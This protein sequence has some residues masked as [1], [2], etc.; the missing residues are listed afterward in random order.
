LL[1]AIKSSQGENDLFGRIRETV[2]N[3]M[4]I[5]PLSKFAS[6]NENTKQLRSI[7]FAPSRRSDHDA[8]TT[9]QVPLVV[10]D[11]AF[12]GIV[13][14]GSFNPLHRG[15]VELA[16]AAQKV[17]KEFRNVD[18]PIAFEIA[19]NNA[20]KGTVDTSIVMNRVYQFLDGNS[21]LGSWPV[22]VTNCALF[23]QKANLLNNCVFVIGADTAIRL[24]DKKYYDNDEHCM[25]LALE[26]FERNGCSFVVAGRFNE[27]GDDKRFIDATEVLNTKI[28]VVFKHMFIPLKE[29]AFR[30]DISSTQLRQ[31]MQQK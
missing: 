5:D 29:A 11:F 21:T 6:T 2:H 27:K 10:K 30:N 14:P 3:D 31:Q 4:D 20:D 25:I 13:L 16:L 8:S 1:E 19:V 18:L 24:V 9:S 22:L 26:Q 23:T 15:H 7:M 28:P 17:V 12:H